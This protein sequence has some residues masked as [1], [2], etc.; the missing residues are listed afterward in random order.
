MRDAWRRRRSTIALTVGRA[1]GR[2]SNVWVAT[3]VSRRSQPVRE[4]R[5]P[6][7]TRLV[8]SNNGPANEPQ[9]WRS[10]R[11]TRRRDGRSGLCAAARA[12]VGVR[13]P[14]ACSNHAATRRVHHGCVVRRSAPHGAG[15][16][17][18]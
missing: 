15:R 13:Q 6:L 9:W 14:L 12:G 4:S 17:A 10:A 11:S 18:S 8:G 3:A 7:V 2:A 1:S 5:A 16:A